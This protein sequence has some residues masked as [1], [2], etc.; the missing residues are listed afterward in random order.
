MIFEPSGNLK[1]MWQRIRLG[2]RLELGLLPDV[3]EAVDLGLLLREIRRVGTAE[4]VEKEH[5]VAIQR[6]MDASEV[7]AH[8]LACLEAEI[9]E[10]ERADD[11][12]AIGA[13]RADVVVHAA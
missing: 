11:V 9:A 3:G 12:D 1:W 7:A 13:H 2:H 4:R 5:A 10:V 6:F 8:L